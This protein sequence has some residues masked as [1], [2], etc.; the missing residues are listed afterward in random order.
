[1]L[2]YRLTAVRA[3]IAVVREGIFTKLD[4]APPE[5]LSLLHLQPDLIWRILALVDA[6][7]S[8]GIYATCRAFRR[9]RDDART[10]ST[11]VLHSSVM[12]SMLF[13]HAADGFSRLE[14]LSLDE[15]SLREPYGGIHWAYY[16]TR[17]LFHAMPV[18]RSLSLTV[19]PTDV[20][21]DL[22]SPMRTYHFPF[23]TPGLGGFL[24]MPTV[25]ESIALP[26][27]NLQSLTIDCSDIPYQEYTVP[28]RDTED[29]HNYHV[30]LGI[31]AHGTA[32]MQRCFIRGVA[33][34]NYQLVGAFRSLKSFAYAGCEELDSERL[35]RFI[36]AI[37]TLQSL[38]LHISGFSDSTK[39]M[40]GNT[41]ATGISSGIQEASELIPPSEKYSTRF[42]RLRYVLVGL[43]GRWGPNHEIEKSLTNFFVRNG[44]LDIALILASNDEHNFRTWGA[45][46]PEELLRVSELACGTSNVSIRFVPDIAQECNGAEAPYHRTR[47]LG[48]GVAN[49]AYM[50][51]SALDGISLTH[52]TTLSISER[53]ARGI[54][55]NTIDQWTRAVGPVGFN[56][57]PTPVPGRA[58][59]L[60]TFPALERLTVWLVSCFEFR[61]SMLI[62]SPGPADSRLLEER[63]SPAVSATIP[64]RF[65]SLNT[66]ELSAGTRPDFTRK[67][68]ILQMFV[69]C[70]QMEEYLNPIP[71]FQGNMGGC[72]CDRPGGGYATSLYDLTEFL[73]DCA[74]PKLARVHVCAIDLVDYDLAGTFLTTQHALPSV[75][76]KFD[77]YKAFCDVESVDL[78]TPYGADEIFDHLEGRG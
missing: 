50:A 24:D 62:Y 31:F 70:R 28:L 20:Y 32:S 11:A 27:P 30:P 23:E 6:S 45:Q 15:P 55:E 16:A 78:F 72:I 40:G 53:F 39:G 14:H 29:S 42:A 8:A 37:P 71:G 74:F 12:E 22:H 2:S 21:R 64:A 73:V 49:G 13:A 3:R 47:V 58:P 43:N 46:R 52:L 35:E 69:N 77:A 66:F 41:A 36:E 51:R 59:Q 68:D 48:A 61:R 44:A 60:M 54:L 9:A 76:W 10:L 26:M 57:G 38:R 56:L 18:L 65:P 67:A 34:P 25:N 5:R 17:F 4:T 75:E 33:W 63:I 19:R 7:E 1:M